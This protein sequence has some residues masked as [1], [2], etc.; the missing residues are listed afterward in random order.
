MAPILAQMPVRPLTPSPIAT[1]SV[2]PRPRH[3]RPGARSGFTLIELLIVAVV[4]AILATVLIFGV[5]GLKRRA[6]RG[7][8][9]TNL[10]ALHAAIASYVS[11]NKQW[12]QEP[13]EFASSA[14]RWEWWINTFKSYDVPEDTWVCPTYKRL[15]SESAYAELDLSERISYLP[16]MYDAGQFTPYKWANQPW[17]MEIGDFHGKGAFMI[18][19]DGSL[20]ESREIL[21]AAAPRGGR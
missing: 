14:Q 18:F 13:E 11:D 20:V 17:L 9:M 3:P 12:P 10:R 19:P 2:P 6:E 4:I 15:H 1:A 5:Q 8:C 7:R 21:G 16:Q